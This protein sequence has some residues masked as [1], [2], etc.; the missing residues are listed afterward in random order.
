MNTP[1]T[2]PTSTFAQVLQSFYPNPDD[3]GPWG[4]IG[5]I[6]RAA[7][8]NAAWSRM[9]AIML[10]PQPLPPGAGPVPDP[11]RAAALARMTIDRAV[12]QFQ[13][14]ET[15]LGREA[16]EQA[17]EAVGMQIQ[18]FV[19]D[20]CGTRPR[21]W[22]RPWPWPPFESEKIEPL[23]LLIAGAQF[24]IAAR[25]KNP[26]QETFAAAAEQLMQTGVQRLEQERV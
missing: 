15:L 12:S 14:T 20:Y 7:L 10:N 25:A 11:W 13:L 6:I 23:D 2:L 22:P 3:S 21:P 26:L 4:P 19:D 16:S 18:A 5:P 8:G 17:I 24:E 9:A 1:I